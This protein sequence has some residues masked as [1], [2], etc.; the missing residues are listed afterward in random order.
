MTSDLPSKAKNSIIR[1]LIYYDKV[2]YNKMDLI[3]EITIDDIERVRNDIL[4]D[5]YSF[6]VGLPK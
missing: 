3:K 1:D 4:L 2:L 6:I 5:N